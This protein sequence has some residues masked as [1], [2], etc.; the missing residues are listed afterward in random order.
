[1]PSTAQ[2]AASNCR[3]AMRNHN[4]RRARQAQGSRRRFALPTHPGSGGGLSRIGARPCRTIPRSNALHSTHFHAKAGM[5]PVVGTR[6]PDGSQTATPNRPD[7]ARNR[8]VCGDGGRRRGGPVREITAHNQ[9]RRVQRSAG[10]ER[11]VARG[12]ADLR[13]PV[14]R[15]RGNAR[16][17]DGPSLLATTVE[18]SRTQSSWRSRQEVAGRHRSCAESGIADQG[19]RGGRCAAA[20]GTRTRWSVV[21]HCSNCAADCIAHG[22]RSAVRRRR[23]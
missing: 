9:I 21:G 17:R 5:R 14:A 4:R 6:R 13:S 22:D 15:R 3:A 10:C 20:S 11:G 18:S 12:G 23:P 8:S 16:V 2:P 7:S 19:W 1:M